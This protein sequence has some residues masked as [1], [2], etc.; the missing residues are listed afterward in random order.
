[1][2]NT[3]AKY[4]VRRVCA[5]A[6][7]LPLLLSG[8]SPAFAEGAP[9]AVNLATMRQAIKANQVTMKV[10]GDGVSTTKLSL[11][12]SNVSDKPI[13]LVIPQNEVL[14]PNSGGVQTMLINQDIVVE[15]EA[16]K[17]AIV[18][19]RTV[20][21]SPK[22]V[23]PPPRAQE[24][25]NFQVG[26]YKNAEMWKQIAAI[27][28]AGKEL[29]M[30]GAFGTLLLPSKESM[31]KL[32]ED[33]IR[34]ETN[35]RIEK[36]LSDNPTQNKEQADAAIKQEMESIKFTAER[37]VTKRERQKR[38]DQ[39]T[40]IAIWRMLGISSG[41][42]QDSVTQGSLES[43]I[44]KELTQQVKNDKTLLARLGGSLDKNGN[45]VPSDKQKQALDE[46]TSAIFDI[47]DLTVRRSSEAGLTGI[48]T[49]PKDDPVDTFC[50]VGERSFAQGNYAE[51]QE[52]LTSA[53]SEAE[54]LGEADARL[55]RALNS[56]GLC[57]LDMT[58]YDLAQA[59]LDR[60]LK[61]REKV[62][63]PQS[64][65]VAEVDNNLGLLKQLTAQYVPADQ[66]FTTAITIFEKT[67][68]KTSDTVAGSLNNLG[69]NLCLQN[70]ADDGS[71][72]LKRA[73]ALAIINCPSDVKGNK[74][75]TPFVA[76]V[77]TNLADAYSQLGKNE[78]ATT[79]YQKALSVDVKALSGEHPFIAKILD[80]LAFVTGKQGQSGES[81]NFKRQADEIRTKVLGEDNLEIAA[82]PLGTAAFGRIWEYQQGQK[83]IKA[84]VDVVRAGTSLGLSQDTTR[85]NRPIKDKW[86]LV[87]GISKFKDPTIN[88]QYAAKDAADF[89]DYLVKE[90]NFAPDHVRLLT[91]E[92]ATRTSIMS[93]IGG[94]WLP[95]VANPDDLVMIFFSSHGS[96]TSLDARSINYLV[97]YDTD[98][99]DLYATGINLQ[100]FSKEIKERIA[101]QRVVLVMD[102]CHSG[103]AVGAKGMFR[104]I[105][106]DATQVAQGTGQMV[107]CSSGGSQSS[108][109][110]ARYKNGV[111]TH[112][113]LEG[114]R[115]DGTN[116]KIASVFDYMKAKVGEEVQMDRHGARQTPAL[117]SKWQGN[118]LVIGVKPAEPRPGI[119]DGDPN[120]APK[121]GIPTANAGKSVSA[122]SG[123]P[124]TAAAASSAGKTPVKPGVAKSGVV[125]GP[126]K[127]VAPTKNRA[128]VH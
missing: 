128:G 67:A 34:D 44:I 122:D 86:A 61:L 105:G 45:F 124:N 59:D 80:G 87:I 66:L 18:N 119:T 102:A 28:A 72:N 114:L 65:E 47:V 15:I 101:A 78:E 12:L 76:E 73:L 60:A 83:G 27:I 20:C 94:K 92:K 97:A 41:K 117:Q 103:A 108:W 9:P 123:A 5:V 89:A 75:Y 126:A 3:F 71:S 38:I 107:I 57:H 33:E 29:D 58:R 69:K 2:R 56:L 98:K 95:R 79:L 127:A 43:D 14:H 99:N 13:K 74:L 6:I 31:A 113:L 91:N 42:P 85:M 37:N 4:L 63:G 120:L 50:S 51:A 96:P 90:G 21:A 17:T 88:L 64:Q 46:R 39:I 121:A 55:S 10:Q 81:D 93:N 112:Y 77:E 106:V 111:F 25:L 70:K 35:R 19:L 104:D 53:V 8:V 109:E 11:Q 30:V 125:K 115:K 22:T 7:L 49:L 52:L 118:D 62:N 24:G 32:V 68:G 84:S 100:E 54:K 23:P 16:G 48:A 26:D 82:L 36:Y 1:M 110:S 40:Q 116:A